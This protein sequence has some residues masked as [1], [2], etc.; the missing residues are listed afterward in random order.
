MG[1]ML[2]E[3]PTSLEAIFYITALKPVRAV[4]GEGAHKA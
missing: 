2:K 4:P 1:I 3:R